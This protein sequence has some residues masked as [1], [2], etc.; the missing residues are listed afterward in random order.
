M[1]IA[2]EVLDAIKQRVAVGTASEL[3]LA[4]Q[5]SV[6]ATQNAPTFRRSS[7]TCSRRAQPARRSGRDARRKVSA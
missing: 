4:Q 3:D 2:S 5:E 7:R 6:V 1:K